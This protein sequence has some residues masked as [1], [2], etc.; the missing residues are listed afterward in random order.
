MSE[1]GD[2][3]KKHYT[4]YGIR[5]WQRLERYP[6]HQLEF[7]T[8]MHFLKKYLP[9][10]GNILDAGGGPGRYTIN[11]A[12]QGYR[13]T[14]L[15]CTHKLL[16]IAEQKIKENGVQENVNQ[17]IEGSIEDLSCFQDGEF[18]A[19]LCLGGPMNHLVE[20][21]K[22]LAASSELVRVAKVGAPLFISVIGRLA[23]CMN[24]INQF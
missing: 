23:A 1:Y 21:E 11:L 13:V 15:D 4:E 3:V 24:A 8:T 12:K 14:L 20:K 22:R 19:V 2:K 5:E 6:Y 9:E 17:I 7:N 10:K 16:E 18:D